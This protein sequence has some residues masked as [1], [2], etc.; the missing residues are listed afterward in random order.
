[1]TCCKPFSQEE[2]GLTKLESQRIL[3]RIM[4]SSMR[5]N[6]IDCCQVTGQ[7][8]LM[9]P[10]HLADPV[11]VNRIAKPQ[12]RPRPFCALRQRRSL[13]HAISVQ[14]DFS[15][16]PGPPPSSWGPRYLKVPLQLCHVPTDEC[17]SAGALEPDRC[18]AVRSVD[19]ARKTLSA[20]AHIL[21]V[22]CCHFCSNYH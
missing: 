19:E 5:A 2:K 15:S 17:W 21:P 20:S 10:P 22:P 1:M 14:Q 4:Y 12:P 7:V 6:N 8:R 13:P 18:H 9:R 16:S 3:S 11:L